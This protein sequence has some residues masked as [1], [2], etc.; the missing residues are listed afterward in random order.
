MSKS[1]PRKKGDV[2]CVVLHAK[3]PVYKTAIISNTLNPSFES[4][5]CTFFLDESDPMLRIMFFEKNLAGRDDVLGGVFVNLKDV[6]LYKSDSESEE[7]VPH[8][9]LELTRRNRKEFGP[10]TRSGWVCVKIQINME[11]DSVEGMLAHLGTPL[12]VMP[13]RMT[14]LD[15][16]LMDNHTVGGRLISAATVTKWDHVAIVMPKEGIEGL[17]LM[18]ATRDGVS[19]CP[20]EDRVKAILDTGATL[21]VRRLRNFKRT[22][23]I[24]DTLAD[25]ASEHNGK[26][27]EESIST[28][29]KSKFKSNTEAD[30][31]SLFCSELV[32]AAY[33]RVLI[34]QKSHVSSNFS[35]K[36]FS[37]D[38][39]PGL[40]YGVLDCVKK[41]SKTHFSA[42]DFERYTSSPSVGHYL[43]A[44]GLRTALRR[45]SQSS[46]G[47]LESDDSG[48][49][50]GVGIP[51][52]RSRRSSRN[53]S[54]SLGSAD[55]SKSSS[56]QSSSVPD[57]GGSA[58]TSPRLSPRVSPR[59]GNRSESQPL[60]SVAV[61]KSPLA[62]RAKSKKIERRISMASFYDTE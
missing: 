21:G 36:D 14:H 32:A 43:K 24:R 7:A 13:F 23:A 60:S 8:M 6:C 30:L 44:D 56:T 25:F 61:E 4:Q 34:I 51:I 19:V 39:V 28:L 17:A 38:V 40:T 5:D 27:Y 9:W 16:I 49:D 48:G 3:S 41:F 1:G 10:E 58:K 59:I 26:P 53:L 37:L 55:S 46:E 50:L 18:E 54:N 2:Y 12:Q 11:T 47:V 45:I 42:S 31:S 22:R 35:P 33:Q 15:L 57:E 29:I 52:P 20:L 62:G